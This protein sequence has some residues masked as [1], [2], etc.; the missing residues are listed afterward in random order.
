MRLVRFSLV[1]LMA[2]CAAPSVRA[3]EGKWVSLF[4]GKDLDGWTACEHPDSFRVVDGELIVNGERGHLF[5]T[6]DV[7]NGD[8]KDF[9]WKCEVLTKPNSNSGMYIHT[10]VQKEGWPGKGYEVQ[11]NNTHPDP[12]KTGGLYGIVDVMDKSPVKD[13]EWFTQHV[14]VKGKKIIV[15]VNDK[16]T[17]DYTEPDELPKQQADQNR[18]LSHGTFAI[19]AHDPGSEVHYRKIEVKVPK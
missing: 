13:N 4:N 19:Q 12:R 3:E 5:Y 18:R 11:V 17:V 14:I 1:G 15:K 8:F 7:N 10:E 16:V 9:E 6:G 2:V